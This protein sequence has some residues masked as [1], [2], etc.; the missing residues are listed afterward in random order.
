MTMKKMHLISI[1]S[2]LLL[3]ISIKSL[4]SECADNKRPEITGRPEFRKV[5]YYLS[6]EKNGEAINELRKIAD[7]NQDMDVAATAL[8]WLA[9]C[10]GFRAAVPEYQ[11]IVNRYPGTRYWF[12]AKLCIIWRTADKNDDCDKPI[13]MENQVIKQIGGADVFEFIKGNFDDFDIKNVPVQYRN[14]LADYYYSTAMLYN[15]LKYGKGQYY[16]RKIKLL[17]LVREKFIKVDW[18]EL[19]VIGEINWLVLMQRG[20]LS[21]KD[22]P[23][24]IAPPSIRPIAPHDGLQIGETQ[25]KI[26]IEIEDGDISQTQVDLSKFLFTLDSQDLTD[27]M[28]VKSTINTSGQL[29]PT[30][31]K[32]QLT[33]RPAT[34]LSIGLHTVYVKATDYGKN[35]SEKTWRFYVKK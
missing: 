29:G 15:R 31:E 26:E 22:F 4:N 18:K 1:I 7:E 9:D 16:D 14:D 19:N 23:H 11:E 3:L 28:K 32:L 27:V 8:L 6:I 5:R 35:A 10:K 12:T 2:C 20:I 17:T 13:S 24:D 25:P 33:Y 34:P 21:N 30:F